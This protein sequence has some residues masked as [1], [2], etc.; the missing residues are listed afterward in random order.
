MSKTLIVII[1]FLS[2]ISSYSQL[3]VRNDNYIFVNDKVI[4]VED[5]IGLQE[6][7]SKFYLRNEAQLLQ[8]NGTTGNSGLGQLSIF[9]TGT[10]HE[11]AYNYW[12]SPVG[13]NSLSLGNEVFRA[14][15]ID[16][17]TGLITSQN[18]QFTTDPEG[19]IEDISGT[20][21]P[22][23]IS[24]EWL[25]TFE[26]ASQYSGWLYQSETG[27][28]SPGLGFT[29]K[30]IRG[31]GS[32]QTYDFRG[33]PNN[34]TIT[35]TVTENIWTLIGNPYPSAVDALAYIHDVDNAAAINGV[36]YFWEQD[37][38]VF[39]HN[40]ADY[41]GGY[42]LYTISSDGL[43]E[44]YIHAPFNTYNSDGTINT[45]GSPRSS[46]K[47][48]GRYIPVAVSYTHLTLPTIA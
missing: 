41:V 3:Y 34:G 8:G 22:L 1:I 45:A 26:N 13:N 46:G 16:E 48:L 24:S 7:D 11:Y 28:I 4:F 6:T 18:A 30:G 12:C 5:N 19:F 27:N 23:T 14:N 42:A 40:L 20:T 38:S 9:Q 31:S 44:T 35:N 47:N 32:N 2:S 37:L 15:L 36:L 25:Y 39:S 21:T 43:V 29:M 17:S 33:K 10:T